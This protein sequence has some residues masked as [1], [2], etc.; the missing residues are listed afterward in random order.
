[1]SVCTQS[2]R[3]A[4]RQRPLEQVKKTLMGEELWNTEMHRYLRLRVRSSGDGMRY[5]VNLQTTSPGGSP[6]QLPC[7]PS[8]TIQAVHVL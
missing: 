4:L 7:L 8:W 6:F 5:F 1:M 2:R 3:L